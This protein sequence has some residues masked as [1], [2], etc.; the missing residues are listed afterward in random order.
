MVTE[1]VRWEW[2][3]EMPDPTEIEQSLTS[4]PPVM[5]VPVTEAWPFILPMAGRVKMHESDDGTRTS[6]QRDEAREVYVLSVK[7]YV[8]V[9]GRQFLAARIAEERDLS[10]DL[11]PDPSIEPGKPAFISDKV[12]VYREFCEITNAEGRSLGRK[13]GMAAL[14]VPASSDRR[15]IPPWEKMETAARGRALGAWGIGVLPGS[16]VA[17]LEEMELGNRPDW[18]PA[19]DKVEEIPNRETAETELW[20]AVRGLQG[21]KGWDDERTAKWF[22]SVVLEAFQITTE[23]W[24]V[25]K[26]SDVQV[27]LLTR[28]V[29]ADTRRG[30]AR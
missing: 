2:F 6:F 15:K 21:A 1:R 26:L 17:S 5:G 27:V 9:A 19:E 12:A 11:Y 30:R 23:G 14:K 25:T 7:L 13:S 10:I 20:E 8:Q 29:V 4:L 16:G 3:D 28:R 22:A 24:D 18:E